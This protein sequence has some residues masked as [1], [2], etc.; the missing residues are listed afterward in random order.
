M[1]NQSLYIVE[2]AY[3]LSN[4]RA[5]FSWAYLQWT[6]LKTKLKE[7]LVCTSDNFTLKAST[8][9]WS[10]CNS[11]RLTL[12]PC[13]LILY[14]AVPYNSKQE[15]K[16]YPAEL[17]VSRFWSLSLGALNSLIIPCIT[18]KMYWIGNCSRIY[19]AFNPTGGCY[20]AE[21]LI[22]IW[23]RTSNCW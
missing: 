12:H 21:V 14:R 16:I 17:S 18:K 7:D 5:K 23:A 20:W 8:T 1:N 6:K 2:R 22:T 19:V 11:W 15:V 3:V 13:S 9:L 4:E 10:I